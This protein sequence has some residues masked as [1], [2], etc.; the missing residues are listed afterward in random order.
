MW[1]FIGI[2]LLVAVAIWGWYEWWDTLTEARNREA[3]DKVWEDRNG[4][5]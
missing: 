1:G 5:S 2:A 3:W 4:P